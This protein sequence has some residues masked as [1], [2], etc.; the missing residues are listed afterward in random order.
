M[1]SKPYSE[2]TAQVIDEEVS[3]I[4]EAAYARAKEII[5]LN[6]ENVIKLANLLL[7]K[8]VIFREDVEMIFGKRL[9]DNDR[10]AEEVANEV[11]SIHKT[12]EQ[13]AEDDK[14]NNAADEQKND[15]PLP[16]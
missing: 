6:K 3:S 14:K 12:T 8:E 4:V 16:H 13:K 1:L 15:P 7:E 11:R 10:H 5:T 2:Q 9:F